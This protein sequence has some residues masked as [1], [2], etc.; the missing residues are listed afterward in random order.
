[1]GRGNHLP[2]VVKAVPGRPLCTIC[3]VGMALMSKKGKSGKIHFKKYCKRCWRI[4]RKLYGPIPVITKSHEEMVLARLRSRKRYR[5]FLKERCEWC[6]FAPIHTCQLD[7]DHIDN[8]RGN[9]NPSNLR[10]LCSN[11]HRL[12]QVVDQLY[13]VLCY[14]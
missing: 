1:M 14:M 3:L 9:N 7:V 11:C 5:P 2:K 8:N 12:R 4:R 13:R 10:T 6:Q